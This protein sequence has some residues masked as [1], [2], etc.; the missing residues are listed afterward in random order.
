MGLCL[1]LKREQGKP[2]TTGAISVKNCL[3]AR[4]RAERRQRA[5]ASSPNVFR[6]ERSDTIRNYGKR[7]LFD[8]SSRVGSPLAL[9]AY[10]YRRAVVYD[11]AE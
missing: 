4:E 5:P 6:A 7:F 8:V 3:K 2:G 10:R 1:L 9:V 11:V